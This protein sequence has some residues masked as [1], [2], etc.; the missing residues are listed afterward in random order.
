MRSVVMIKKTFLVLQILFAGQVHAGINGD[1]NQFFDK[2]G[3]MS[4]ATNPGVYNSQ[5]AGSYAGGSLFA[6]DQIRQYQ[7]I[8]LDLPSYRAGCG[9]ID[10]YMG[11]M[12]FLSKDNM[13]ALGKSIMTNG[14]AYGFELAMATTVPEIKHVKD[15]LQQAQQFINQGSINSC[16]LSQNFVGGIWPKTLASQDKICK[17]QGTMGKQG[18][19]SDYVQARMECS[20]NKREAAIDAASQDP[21]RRR[22]VVYNKNIV[23]SLLKSKSFLASDNELCEMMMSLTGTIIIDKQG[24]VQNVPSLANSRNLVKALIGRDDGAVDNAKIWKCKDQDCLS[25]SLQEIRIA[26]E[27]TLRFKISKLIHKIKDALTQ[28]SPS[29]NDVNQI[30]SFASMVHIP[31]VKFT[32][33]M[34]STEYGDSI[35]DL[36]DLSTLIAED[37]LQQYLNELLQ[38]V[39][40]VTAGSELT[41]D[42][43]K[44]ITKRVTLARTEIAKL[45]P[46]IG[47]KLQQKFTLINNVQ[48][49]EQQVATR[50]AQELG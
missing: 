34:L 43:I 21:V 8:Q 44:D 22:Q 7:L 39:S 29:E 42:L 26:E 41:E 1:L 28:T 40:N 49:I 36:S 38:E 9:G 4:N 27:N 35:V 12:S 2:L 20:G 45:D 46:E 18:F 24:H 48:H 11:S 15:A 31:V 17:D 33:V 23:W 14:T 25:V 16:E 6:R 30:S 13:V 5:A 3:Y 37:L 19:F 50:V 32:E 47:Q 10:L